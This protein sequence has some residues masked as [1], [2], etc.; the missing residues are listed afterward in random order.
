MR[1]IKNV[2]DQNLLGRHKFMPRLRN[3]SRGG[4]MAISKTS[5]QKQYHKYFLAFIQKGA[6]GK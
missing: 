2:H 4:I 5:S 3:I 6:N 1:D